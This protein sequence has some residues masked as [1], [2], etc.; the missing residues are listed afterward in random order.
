MADSL[1]KLWLSGLYI[2]YSYTATKTLLFGLSTKKYFLF[3]KWSGYE[4][5][6]PSVLGQIVQSIFHKSCAQ[7]GVGMGTFFLAAS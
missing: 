4:N 2:L 1:T 7:S 3:S 6:S 5:S